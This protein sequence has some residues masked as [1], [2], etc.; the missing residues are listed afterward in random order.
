MK[1]IN[2]LEN[3]ILI[4][5][6][7]DSST[8]FYR[9]I[10]Y[11]IIYCNAIKYYWKVNLIS[12]IFMTLIWNWYYSMRVR[13]NFRVNYKIYCSLRSPVYYELEMDTIF[14]KKKSLVLKKAVTLISWNETKHSSI[15][16]QFIPIITFHAIN[17][18]CLDKIHLSR[19]FFI[20]Y[21]N[22]III[23]K[24]NNKSQSIFTPTHTHT[25]KWSVLNLPSN[26]LEMMEWNK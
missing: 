19:D 25:R 11:D 22:L 5:T 20:I 3:T 16:S 18:Y 24:S 17:L 1:I 2:S 26:L 14:D 7:V 21:L 10:L 15:Y 8:I 4:D 9:H 13:S 6:K 12:V 23:N